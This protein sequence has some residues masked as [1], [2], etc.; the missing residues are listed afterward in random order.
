[1]FFATGTRLT[2]QGPWYVVRMI[3]DSK[4]ISLTMH[5]APRSSIMYY[6]SIPG[7][8]RRM[9]RIV[10]CPMPYSPDSRVYHSLPCKD[11]HFQ[12]NTKPSYVPARTRTTT[13]SSSSPSSGK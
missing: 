8:V 13:F 9:H 10:R 3:I 1:M 11:C 12:K 5:S 4:Y 7:S 6:M 2:V